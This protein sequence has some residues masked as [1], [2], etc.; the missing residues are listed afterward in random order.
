[1]LNQA[2]E[3]LSIVALFAVLIL[4]WSVTPCVLI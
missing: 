2:A 1:M 3:L 4:G